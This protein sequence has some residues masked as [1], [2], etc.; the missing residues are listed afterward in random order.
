MS[1]Q[2][3]E[4]QLTTSV[5]TAEDVSLLQCTLSKKAE[6]SHVHTFE[7][8]KPTRWGAENLQDYLDMKANAPDSY[9]TSF[10]LDAVANGTCSTV[11]GSEAT[12]GS[13][14]AES[15]AIGYQAKVDSRCGIAIGAGAHTTNNIVIGTGATDEDGSHPIVIGHEGAG[16]KLIV[17]SNGDLTVNGVSMA[18]AQN[19]DELYLSFNMFTAMTNEW[20]SQLQTEASTHTSKLTTACNCFNDITTHF[21]SVESCL[22]TLKTQAS[23]LKTA[24]CTAEQGISNLGVCVSGLQSQITDNDQ[25]ITALGTRVA[26]VESAIPTFTVTVD[27]ELN[28]ESENPVQNKVITES[29]NSFTETV[30]G[31][32]ESVTSITETIGGLSESVTSLTEA[33]SSK[34]DTPTIE[35]TSNTNLGDIDVDSP[36]QV[37]AVPNLN[38]INGVHYQKGTLAQLGWAG[39][40]GYIPK[41]ISFFRRKDKTDNG[42]KNLWLRILR[43]DGT[44]WYV[45]YQANQ[46]VKHNSYTNKGQRILHT[47]EW[48]TGPKYIGADEQ[49]LLCYTDDANA[50]ASQ[51]IAFGGMSMPNANT[52][53]ATS[54]TLPASADQGPSSEVAGWSVAFH[55]TYEVSEYYRE[56]SDNLLAATVVDSELLATSTNPV[57]NKV[58]HNALYNPAGQ[59]VLG[60]QAKVTTTGRGVAVGLNAKATADYP[61]VIT[62][63][64]TVDSTGAIT[65]QDPSTMCIGS[66]GLVYVGGNLL[67]RY[68][69]M[70]PLTLALSEVQTRLDRVE[71]LLDITAASEDPE[72]A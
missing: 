13:N 67:L 29:I 24:V 60:H 20:L 62:S 34:Q 4:L 18:A 5:A 42:D 11:L 48:K 36:G 7:E 31:V 66:T 49:I 27:S 53:L 72:Q 26:A 12:T 35:E 57:Q 68:E 43:Y 10:G 19:V 22:T 64:I 33:V 6:A 28:A 21:Q 37:A 41:T 3:K 40:G 56:I 8:V 15:V 17:H 2:L 1:K 55:A 25:D 59:V 52:T 39:A 9:E 69:D 32:T 47:M 61:V 65:S 23:S 71:Q 63:G 16:A 30:T 44:K 51:V 50:S 45:A 46:F 58:L 14:A 38:R 54:A 70:V